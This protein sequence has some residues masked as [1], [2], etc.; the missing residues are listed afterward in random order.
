MTTKYDMAAQAGDVAASPDWLDTL[1]RDA[2]RRESHVDDAGFT[3]NVLARLP[4]TAPSAM[5][6]WILW[7]FG[8]LACLLGLG[9]LGGGAFIWHA[10]LAVTSQRSFGAP[11]LAVLAVAALFYWFVLS[12]IDRKEFR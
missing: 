1:L 2:A 6:R 12:S 8:T 5:R 4:S 3:A 11:Q 7:G 9:V 10:A